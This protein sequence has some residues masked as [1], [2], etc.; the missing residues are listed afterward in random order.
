MAS[1]FKPRK[2]TY[3][4]PNGS[5]RTPDG[6]RVTKSTPGAVK[7]DLGESAVWYGK[8]KT[9]DGRPQTV[10]LCADKTA[11]K[12]MLA[13]LVTDARLATVGIGDTYVE[14]RRRPLREHLEDF[15]AALL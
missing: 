12:Q 6:K 8:Y 13:K 5:Y 1:L 2:T 3:R 14:H 9:A 7:V 4:L 15:H 10:P 11:A